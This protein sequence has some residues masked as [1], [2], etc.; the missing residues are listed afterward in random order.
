M[1]HAH[2]SPAVFGKP[3]ARCRIRCA[4]PLSGA[5]LLLAAG[6]GEAPESPRADAAPRAEREAPNIVEVAQVAGQ[7]STLLRAAQAA[8]LATTLAEEGPFT[9]FAPTDGAF[10]DLPEGTVE[11]LLA[12]PDALRGILLYHVVAGTH[13]LADLREVSELESVEGSVLRFENTD[14]GLTVNGTFL[15]TA[16]VRASNGIVHVI[17]SVVTP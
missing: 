9:V 11:A 15:L 6:C 17:T 4:F 10:A 12:D 8:G 5:M 3:R 13:T 14:R 7:F 16:D 2:R 1:S